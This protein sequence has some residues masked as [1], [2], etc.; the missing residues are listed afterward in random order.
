A[1]TATL[2]GEVV[3]VDPDGTPHTVA[4][5]QRYVDNQGDAWTRSFDF[6]K[7]AIDELALPAVG[8]GEPAERDGEPDALLGYAAFAG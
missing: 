1:N 5:L 6:L 3:H 8:D 7:R 2:A 4:I